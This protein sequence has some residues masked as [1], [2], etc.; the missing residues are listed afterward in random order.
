LR[1]DTRGK[2]YVMAD[3]NPSCHSEDYTP[4]YNYF[5]TEKITVKNFI[6]N[7][8]EDI[9]LSPNMI[10]FADTEFVIE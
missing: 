6:S 10:L 8:D 3:L 1:I 2:T 9:L 7:S 4:E 5:V